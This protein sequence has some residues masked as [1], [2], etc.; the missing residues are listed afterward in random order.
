MEVEWI[1]CEERM[2]PVEDMAVWIA[3][4]EQLW[5]LATLCDGK[6]CHSED[7]WF[8]GG[9]GVSLSQIHVTHWAEVDYPDL[10]ERPGV[11]LLDREGNEV[12][13]WPKT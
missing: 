5:G 6:P 7:Y 8:L 1:P 3:N 13:E 12:K 11:S 9:E 4:Y 10:P 2:P